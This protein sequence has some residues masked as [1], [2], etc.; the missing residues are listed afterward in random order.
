MQWFEIESFGSF[1][2]G[3]D[4]VVARIDEASIE[5]AALAV[6]TQA[7]CDALV[8]ACT[9]LRCLNLIPRIEHVTG[10]PVLSSNQALAW[11][12]LRLAGIADQNPQFGMLFNRPVVPA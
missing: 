2:E 3:N 5:R 6:A 1:E 11:H 7:Q 10:I 8:I 12:M 9:N 4:H